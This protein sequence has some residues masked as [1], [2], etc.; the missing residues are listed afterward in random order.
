M[1]LR[2]QRALCGYN[3]QKNPVRVPGERAW[4]GV[5]L[6]QATWREVA[7]GLKHLDL[8]ISGIFHLTFLDSS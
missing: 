5:G 8:F 1:A 6:L 7:R 4:D 3:G 2:E